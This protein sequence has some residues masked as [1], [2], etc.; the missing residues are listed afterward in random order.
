MEACRFY[1]EWKCMLHQFN[2]T[3]IKHCPYSLEQVTIEVLRCVTH[4]KGYQFKYS[5]QKKTLK[6]IDPSNF[7][8]ALAKMSN[9][10]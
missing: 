9:A 7:L 4:F 1:Q 8:W 5:I 10:P 3:G 2:F 6:P